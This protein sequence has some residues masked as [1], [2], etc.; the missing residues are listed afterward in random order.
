MQITLQQLLDLQKTRRLDAA[1]N[2]TYVTNPLA[3]KEEIA[4]GGF[5]APN[6]Y[7]PQYV[8]LTGDGTYGYIDPTTGKQVV[9]DGAGGWAYWDPYGG[10]DSMG[11][12]GQAVPG[13]NTQSLLV[14]QGMALALQSD[15]NLL[16]ELQRS[17]V[18]V[19]QQDRTKSGLLQQIQ[20]GELMPQMLMAAAS[21]AIPGFGPANMLKELAT[22]GTQPVTTMA[23]RL[24]SGGA[25]AGAAGAAAVNPAPGAGLGPSVD[26]GM[27]MQGDPIGTAIKIH[28][29]VGGA[30]WAESAA[31]LGFSSMDAALASVNPAWI[32]AAA[33]GATAGAAAK[34]AAGAAGSGAAAGAGEAAGGAGMFNLGTGAALVGSS[35]ISGLLGQNAAE[36]A[37][38]ATR[39]ASERAAATSLTAT[40]ESIAAQEKALAQVRGDLE[41][42]RNLGSNALP[43]LMSLAG[44]G[45]I[46][47]KPFE[48]SMV[49]M[50]RDPGYEFR[51]SEGEKAIERAAIARG[52][53]ISGATLKEL[54]RYNQDLASNEY[55]SAFGRAFGV[56]SENERT[57][58]GTEAGNRE[59]QFN[60]LATL[61]GMGQNAAAMSGTAGVNTANATTQ[62]LLASGNTSAN[63]IMAG[64]NATAQAEMTAGAGWNNAI[65][66]GLSNYLYMQRFNE[67]MNRM[68][69]FRA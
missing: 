31:K 44:K 35:L 9:E 49:D 13:S 5:S 47:A 10:P 15:P 48:F 11:G 27:V 56:H 53:N 37:A 62:A 40:R 1:G 33:T 39:D 63:A 59:W 20:S 64:G 28:D 25:A 42:Y 19:V 24:A 17:G 23:E 3:G 41:P 18:G 38:A 30:T 66:G 34:A 55:G 67:L 43:Q 22:V 21:F 12:A 46:T 58:I 57:R 50:Y 16:P 65:Q 60:T 69:V 14:P 51:R 7:R 32:N 26:P 29:T 45:D 36:D 6:A 2:Y 68:P 8:D 61:A 4:Y 54:T 52:R